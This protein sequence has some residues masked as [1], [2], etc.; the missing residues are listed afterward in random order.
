MLEALDRTGELDNTL[1]VFTGDN[2][3]AFPRCKAT[4][5]E[6]GIHVP[7]AIRW[8]DVV[9]GGRVVDDF[10]SF[11]DFAPTFLE[12]AGIEIPES[13]T[14]KSL[15]NIL[16]S[17]ESGQIEPE[18]DH[19]VAGVE[20]H[21]PGGR[22][23]GWGYP[24]RAIRTD[25]YLYIHNYAPDRWPA[26]DPDGPVGPDDDMT[27]G[28]GDIDGCPTKDYLV[29]HKSDLE[30]FYNLAFGM[31][32]EEELY[33]VV[34]DP[35]QLNNLAGD[36]GFLEI[37]AGLRD[38]LDEELMKTEDPRATEKGAELDQYAIDYQSSL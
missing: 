25:R 28:F 20:R 23:G 2:G 10:V 31:R 19:V 21:F 35:F 36:P 34:Q 16:K 17:P 24:I 11:T 26:G 14:G 30:Y 32:P 1:I 9:K 27:G 38:L 22:D 33:D 6:W 5:Y 15:M 37:K 29:A 8:G 4:C 18:R 3:M 7:L 13:M 12:A